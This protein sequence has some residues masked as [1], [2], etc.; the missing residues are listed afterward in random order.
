MDVSS[1]V[2]W[3]TNNPQWAYWIIF[4]IAFLESLAV[5]GILV[6]GWILLVGVGIL[7]FTPEINHTLVKLTVI[8]LVK[9]HQ[10]V[11]DVVATGTQHKLHVLHR[12]TQGVFDGIR[13]TSLDVDGRGAGKHRDHIDPVKVDLRVLGSWHL[14]IGKATQ[15]YRQRK[16]KV[17]E[18]MVG[19]ET[20]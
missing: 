19:K 8:N 3:I 13:D 9:A 7:N 4:A 12:A 1:L 17:R 18:D 11:G 15:D 16:G 20:R 2:D 6:P 10:N 5:V 14:R